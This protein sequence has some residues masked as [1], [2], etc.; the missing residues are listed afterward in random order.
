MIV[1]DVSGSQLKYSLDNLPCEGTKN[2]F[3][4]TFTDLVFANTEKVLSHR[5]AIVK[6]NDHVLHGSG[7][8]PM[9]GKCICVNNFI[10]V[11][12]NISLQT[13]NVLYQVNVT[14]RI[15]SFAAVSELQ[16]A[17]APRRCCL[18]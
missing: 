15:E 16:F 3:L 7:L 13:F 1:M 18:D 5:Y 11:Y 17:V 9:P 2:V 6:H 12:I 10:D 14:N 8:E 4:D